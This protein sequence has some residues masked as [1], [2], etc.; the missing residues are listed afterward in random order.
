MNQSTKNIEQYGQL[1]FYE[2]T[3]NTRK[4]ELYFRAICSKRIK[5]TGVFRLLNPLM[6]KNTQLGQLARELLRERQSVN[7]APLP[8]GT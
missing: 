3:Q 7:G 1:I 6:T 4:R 8:L 5:N 2:R